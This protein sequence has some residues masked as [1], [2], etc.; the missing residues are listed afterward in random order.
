M[1]LLTFAIV[2]HPYGCTV[3]LSICF[4]LIA[5][6]IFRHHETYSICAHLT[7]LLVPPALV[8]F[9]TPQ[10][11]DRSVLGALPLSY[12]VYWITLSLSI[13]VYRLSPLHPLARYPGP[14]GCKVSKL[15]MAII[16]RPGYQHRYYKVQHER[17]GDVVRIGPNELSIRD[18]SVVM[19]LLGPNGVPKGPHA[20]GRM[21]TTN[22]LPMLGIEDIRTH[23]H[24]RR[25]WNRAFSSN[26]VAEYEGLVCARTRQLVQHLEEHDGTAV[27]L[28]TW[29]DYWSYDAMC[30]MTFGGG[31]ELLR[32]GDQSNIW[33]ILSAGM[34]A[35]T[36]FGHVP[37]LGVY[38]GYIP[39]ATRPIKTLM[40]KCHELT[41]KRIGRGT[42]N[43]DLFH[44]LNFEDMP[45][46]SPPP[47][48]QVVSDGILAI[49]GGA[50]TVA[51]A[52]TSLFFCLLSHQEAYKM[53]QH[54]V[55]H[56]YP[57]GVDVYNTKFHREMKY[58]DAVINETMR[59]FPPGVGGSQR[60]IPADY[61][62]VTLPSPGTA[63]W[64]HAY[65]LHRDPNN[66]Y[67]FP[68]DFWPDR[69]ILSS[70]KAT[71][72]MSRGLTCDTPEGFRHNTDAY[73]PFS[74]GPMNCVGKNFA[75]MEMRIVVCALLQRFRFQF[76]DG[77]EPS[78]YEKDFKDYLVGSRPRLPVVI[79]ARE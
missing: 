20:I 3:S 79:R 14:L 54:E 57:S 24:R 10:Q 23:L 49:V 76:C 28:E 9:L 52:L 5:Q 59:V 71:V 51:G 22:D 64:V 67:P 33:S 56:F 42:Q 60:K 73:M 12:I 63:F 68:E 32:D 50:D 58:L 11:S 25:A 41:E 1:P 39:A 75:L 48:S 34:A 13:L 53:L 19:A 55:D 40:T 26:A 46:V 4:A 2:N 47:K 61:G 31:S 74:H 35:M 70:H 45:D 30:D 78:E 77:Y 36:F 21:L 65:S 72:S 37:W 43:R 15:W 8:P 7:L 27:R 66:F 38:F 6:Q 17:Y 29:L 69:W 44:Y 18:P 62:G 16:S